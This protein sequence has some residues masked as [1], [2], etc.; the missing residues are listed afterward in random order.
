MDDVITLIKE[1]VTGYDEYG[2]EVLE[3][4]EREVMC[5]VYG[6]TRTEFYQAATVDMHPE[7]TVRL[8]EAADYE[9]EMM[10]E[11]NDV[12][13]TIIRTYRDRGSFQHARN[14]NYERSDP[15]AIELILERKIGDGKAEEK[16]HPC[17]EMGRGTCR[18]SG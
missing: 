18:H 8:S 14:G 17:D 4:T 12:L 7:I 13:Y 10:A 2:N 5:Q 11:Y 16:T 3:K 9:G 15:N 1:T 6:V